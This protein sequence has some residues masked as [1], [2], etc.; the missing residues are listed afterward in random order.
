MRLFRAIPLFAVIW[1][2]Y[3]LIAVAGASDSLDGKLFEMTLISGA[4]WT[5]STKDLL[6][7]VGLVALFIE[8][9]KATRTSTASILDHALSVLVFIAFLVE[10]LTVKQAGNSVF[11]LLGLMSLLDVVAGFTVTIMGAR[12]DLALGDQARL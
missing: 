2:L 5:V 3:N 11:F 6:L 1:V 12:R 4:V 10:F 7:L 9:F 8:V